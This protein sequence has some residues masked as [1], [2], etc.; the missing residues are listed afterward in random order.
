MD[1]R[2]TRSLREQGVV[3]VIERLGH[4]SDGIQ[5]LLG[6][7]C[8]RGFSANPQ[9][10]AEEIPGRVL[11]PTWVARPVPTVMSNSNYREPLLDRKAE[12]DAWIAAANLLLGSS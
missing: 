10:S 2:S 6:L 3:E 5:R 8:D 4:L 1:W 11:S 7:S 12:L 9:S